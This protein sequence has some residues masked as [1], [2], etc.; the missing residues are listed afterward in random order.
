M[1]LGIFNQCS[2][3]KSESNQRHHIEDS[4]RSPV[5]VEYVPQKRW[6]SHVCETKCMHLHIDKK[7]NEN[8]A[9]FTFKY[10]NSTTPQRHIKLR[11][12]TANDA[13]YKCQTANTSPIENND[14]KGT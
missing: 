6:A 8:I 10:E 11:D 3:L 5:Q 1:Y 4:N 13:R 7:E 9:R 2:C 14:F 12:Y